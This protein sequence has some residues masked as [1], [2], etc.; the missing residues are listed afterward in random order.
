M[1]SRQTL[2]V[3]G[4]ISLRLA[5]MRITRTIARRTN[6]R[7]TSLPHRYIGPFVRLFA[8]PFPFSVFLTLSR[9]LTLTLALSLFFFTSHNRRRSRVESCR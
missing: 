5:I 6:E 1:H 8:F 2:G 7:Y 3:S 4:P 9:T